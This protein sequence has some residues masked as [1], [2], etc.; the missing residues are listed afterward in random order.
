[1]QC[2]EPAHASG[3][4]ASLPATRSLPV[5]HTQHWSLQ[6]VTTTTHHH[7]SQLRLLFL[8]QGSWEGSARRE[9]KRM[10]ERPSVRWMLFEPRWMIYGPWL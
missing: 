5:P 7:S 2:E 4:H 1:M 3:L 9:G 10:G 8:M 6:M